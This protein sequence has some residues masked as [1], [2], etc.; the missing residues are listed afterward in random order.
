MFGIF[1]TMFGTQDNTVLIDAIKDGALLVDVR[2]PGEFSSGSVK[3]AINIP[4]NTLPNQLAKFKTKK[5]VVVFCLS[6]GRSGQAKSI[7]E[8]N[9]IPNV[10]NGGPW[11]SVN[12][13]V[14][15]L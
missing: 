10:I 12:N 2:S 11:T 1:K 9:G 7:L 14:N 8:S 6:G 13:V 3:G 15:N 4:L 5:S